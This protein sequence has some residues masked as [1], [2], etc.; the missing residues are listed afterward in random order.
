[1]A[2]FK[3]ATYMYAIYFL[4]FTLI[5]YDVFGSNTDSPFSKYQYPPGSLACK[6]HNTTDMDCSNRYLADIPFLG[7]NL[8]TTLD[9]SHNQLTAIKGAPF[10]QLPL[11]RSLYLNNNQITSLSSTSFRGL[12][13]LVELNLHG[14]K[15]QALPSGVFFNLTKLETI[16][17]LH[18]VLPTMP[19]EALELNALQ[20]IY[21]T[22]YGN[23]YRTGKVDA[24]KSN[25]KI[26]MLT[27]FLESNL[28]NNTF[29]NFTSILTFIFFVSNT[30]ENSFGVEKG[31]FAPL[32]NVIVLKI[33]IEA[34]PA[35]G[36]L[37]SPL[38]HLTIYAILV[39]FNLAT[40]KSTLTIL[41]KF[42]STLSYLAIQYHINLQ[43]I[44]DDSFIWTP[45]LRNLQLNNNQIN[46]LA[47]Y[48]FNGLIT[49]QGLNLTSND[50]K[51][52]PSDA[53]KVFKTS[54]SLKYLDFSA[55]DISSD[56]A[57]DTFSPVSES[58]TLLKLSTKRILTFNSII[59]IDKLYNLHSLRL[60]CSGEKELLYDVSKYRLLSLQNL[61]II[62]FEIQFSPCSTFPN[63]ESLTMDS[64]AHTSFPADLCLHEC[65]NLQVLSLSR[66]ES[67]T[68]SFNDTYLN[69]TF[70]LLNT[71]EMIQ[72]KL[73]AKINQTNS[74][75]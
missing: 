60:E 23:L 45:Y 24:Y 20:E 56:I 7:Q 6:T 18:N 71:F 32:R 19:N 51:A 49:L 74:F 34:L 52:V 58:L 29:H 1:M 30:P 25:L 9:L 46:Y 63:L 22:I 11:L 43:R 3:M 50:L 73:S 47:K 36:S 53:L 33:S 8:T 5:I 28:N 27:A 54:S 62:N 31:V 41:Q 70:S 68:I 17:L 65:S 59:W 37:S 42:N 55:N 2:T 39:S 40:N 10:E 61:H 21:L 75:N 38:Q 35:L 16:D 44:E 66:F 69:I 26:L 15:I 4:F 64:N 12:W 14:N 48:A 67:R 57:N 72:D 13:L